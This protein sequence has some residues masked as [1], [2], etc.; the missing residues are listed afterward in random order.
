[1][2]LHKFQVSQY[3]PCPVG[4]SDSVAG[5][6]IRIS[7]FPIDFSC[8]AGCQYGFRCP[9]Y[10]WASIIVAY[11]S[12]AAIF[13]VGEQVDGIEVLHYFYIGAQPYSFY[14]S[15]DNNSAGFVAVSVGDTGVSVATFDGGGNM[16]V[17]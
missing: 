14:E 1:V 9:D 4:H 13:I 12:Y 17:D 7:G 15:L 6:D 3:G 5:S 11:Y 16:A 10:L 2:E 8:A